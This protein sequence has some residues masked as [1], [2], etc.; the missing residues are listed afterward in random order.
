MAT[1]AQI[2]A[3]ITPPSDAPTLLATSGATLE[4]APPNV[5]SGVCNAN[6]PN[7]STFNRYVW[8]VWQMCA[9]VT[10]VY[11]AIASGPLA[12]QCSHT[13]QGMMA[14]ESQKASCGRVG[15]AAASPLARV[16]RCSFWQHESGTEGCWHAHSLERS[17]QNAAALHADHRLIDRQAGP[18][19]DCGMLPL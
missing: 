14:Q 2:Q 6:M 10:A 4:V 19:A 18:R 16:S 5:T 8:M 11:V 1:T 17:L 13:L 9:Q 15:R 7:D 12:S 3:T